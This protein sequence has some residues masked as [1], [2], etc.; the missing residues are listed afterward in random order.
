MN[1]TQK[2]L[3][4]LKIPRYKFLI[5]KWK[6]REFDVFATTK[7]GVNK[8]QIEAFETL[9][10]DN[11]SE[12]LFG[13]GAR[14]GKTFLGC[15]WALFNSLSMPKSQWLI[16]RKDLTRIKDTT[17]PTMLKVLTNYGIPSDECEMIGMNTGA[18]ITFKNG[19]KILFRGVGDETSDPNFDK[20]G[21]YDLTG[22]FL[23]ECQEMPFK[24]VEVLK[25]RFSVLEGNYYTD[26]EIEVLK[27]HLRWD[28]MKQNL[29]WKAK[30][31]TLMTCNPS[32]NW[33]YRL[34]YKAKQKGHLLHYRRFIPALVTDNPNVSKEYIDE[35]K[36][37]GKE[38]VERL[39]K[40]NF[41]YDDDNTALTS[42]ETCSAIF[43]NDHVKMDISQKWLIVDPALKGKDGCGI[44]VFYGL[45]WME[46]IEYDTL[47]PEQFIEAVTVVKRRHAILNKNI[48]FDAVGIG[49]LSSASF[50]G[51]QM[52]T[53][54]SRVLWKEDRGK[55]KAQLYQDKPPYRTVN[56]QCSFM[57][58]D[59]INEHKIYCR[60]KVS[61][62]EKQRIIEQ[63]GQLKRADLTED[64]IMTVIGK[65][66]IKGNIGYS[67][68]DY[69]ILRMLM[70]A[71][72]QLKINPPRKEAVTTY[73]SNF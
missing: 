10:N 27:K 58:A 37:S 35:L 34:F 41:E 13:G 39:L 52:Y 60:A 33:I 59:Y 9:F 6:L 49:A 42:I 57:L 36:R 12:L 56:D 17:V 23:E 32:K 61:E 67:P 5:E 14:G 3:E 70:F 44:S 68:T 64:K 22:V 19:S 69:D 18:T 47:T 50:S 28:T 40:G 16:M 25:G 11:V 62:D 55:E 20:F 8:R 66:E 4:Y 53:A 1:I 51:C 31:K 65:D 63:L 72:L 38:T 21:S 7:N 30:P 15:T 29:K 71:Q 45:V 54:N 24:V 26:S 46:R 48:V 2:T 43:T 73:T